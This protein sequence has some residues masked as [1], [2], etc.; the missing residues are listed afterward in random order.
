V[1]HAESVRDEKGIT[2]TAGENPEGNTPLGKPRYRRN[3]RVEG[4]EE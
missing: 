3:I 4:E 2:K 1:G